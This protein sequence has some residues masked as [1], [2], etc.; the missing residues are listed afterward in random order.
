MTYLDRPLSNAYSRLEAWLLI[1]GVWVGLM[2][3]PF[4]QGGVGLGW[5]SLNHHIYL[6]WTAEHERFGV[7]WRAAAS[8]V[9]QWPYLYWPVYA[10]AVHGFSGL[11]AGMVL[12]TLNATTAWPI[13]MV[14]KSCIP[15]TSRADGMARAMAMLMAYASGVVLSQLDTTL[16]DLLA[17]QP[18]LMSV[19]LTISGRHVGAFPHL[20]GLD[21][22]CLPGLLAG[23]SVACKFSNGPLA[24]VLPVLWMIAAAGSLPRRFM[25]ALI[26]GISVLIGF[27]LA[28]G[29]WGLTLWHY[30][31]NPFYSFI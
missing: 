15:G 7:D 22:A 4:I 8:Q 23:V 18:F 16:N 12:S 9:Y 24:L 11:M 25:V 21:Q 20:K 14:V 17:A 31:G 10:M 29:P 19:A 30:F 5:D 28:Y 3:I 13:W 27:G 6:G 2:A 26:G 1:G